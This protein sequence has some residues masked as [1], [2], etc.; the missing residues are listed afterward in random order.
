MNRKKGIKL[1]FAIGLLVILSVFS[2]T[3]VNWYSS[4]FALRRNLTETYLENNNQYAQKVAS[5]AHGL[6]LSMQQNMNSLANIIGRRGITQ[7]ELEDW[8]KTYN[9]YFNSVFTTDANGVIQ[10]M[11]PF[12]GNGNVKPGTKISSDLMK[13]T[14]QNKKPF[15]SEPYIAQS[16]NLVILVSSPIFDED[17]NYRGVV[18]GTI[19]LKSDHA[20]RK[21]LYEHDFVDGSS[22]FVVDR[23][24]TIIYH[25]DEKRINES[26]E[27]HPL[28]QDLI[29]G[30][31]GSSQ[32]INRMGIEYFSGYAYVDYTGWGIIVQ[33]P[34]YIMKEPFRELTVRVIFQALPL[35]FIILGVVALIAYNISKPLNQLARFSE[36]AIK[37][38][39]RVHSL[40]EM[41]LKSKI[42]EIQQ[43]YHHVYNYLVLLNKQV[44]RDGL[45]NLGNR[46]SFDLIIKDWFDHQIP[47]SL[48]LLDI[49]YFKKVNDTFGHLAGDDVLRH[50]SSF[51]QNTS[52][53]EDFC[54]RYGGEEF[55]ILTTVKSEEDVFKIAE[56][57]RI[58]FAESPNPT[59][60]KITISFGISSYRIEDE[61]PEDVIKRADIALYQSKENGR[62]QTTIYK[63]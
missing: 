24:G 62:N 45:T 29:K 2:T 4:S 16:G 36:K 22:V 59:G 1:R 48:V 35:L 50:L 8:Q 56:R 17:G 55:A 6:F 47:F 21:I 49:D 13:Q 5:S 9:N 46:R 28:V 14:L 53:E 18:D 57:I 23:S 7:E 54:F 39:T 20:L 43:L 41:E 30:K 44:Q 37:K 27:D 31:S 52:R 3:M 32:I 10:Y 51:M 12:D 63:G 58:G 33:T 19:Y 34:T 38:E 60:E 61:K 15:I 26:I 40:K 42:Y 25:P 11:Y